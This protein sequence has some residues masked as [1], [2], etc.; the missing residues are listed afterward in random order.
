[1][2]LALTKSGENTYFK[3]KPDE[4]IIS[5]ISVQLVRVKMCSNMGTRS[6]LFDFEAKA[7]KIGQKS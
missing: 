5:V 3:G 7:F 2:E 6:K 1:M 4:L